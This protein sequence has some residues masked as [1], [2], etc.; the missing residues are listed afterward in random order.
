MFRNTQTARDASLDEPVFRRKSEINRYKDSRGNRICAAISFEVEPDARPRRRIVSSA[1]NR[2]A[3]GALFPAAT[4]TG[5]GAV[6]GRWGA[7]PFV[8]LR[9]FAAKMDL[10]AL[11]PFTAAVELAAGS[12]AGGA[13]TSAAMFAVAARPACLNSIDFI[14]PRVAM[15]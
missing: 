4:A 2:G 3:T 15:T 10:L 9:V 6:C 5:D 7:S 12:N 8:T 11:A 14:C 13:D 1:V